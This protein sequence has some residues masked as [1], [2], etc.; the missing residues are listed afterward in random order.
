MT[1]LVVHPVILS[2]GKVPRLIFLACFFP[3]AI[4]LLVLG[5]INRRRYPM[6]VSGVWDFIG[7]LFAASGFLLLAGP[8][9]LSNMNEGWRHYWL[10]GKSGAPQPTLDDVWQFWVFLS[11]LYFVI[12]VAGSG[13]LLWRHRSLTSIYNI[14]AG[15]VQRSLEVVFERLH[16]NPVRSG[17]IYLFGLAGETA[18]P[19]VAERYESVQ[20]PHHLPG[21]I[22]T[23]VDSGAPRAGEGDFLGQTAILEIESFGYFRH[24][25]LRWDPVDNLFRRE[26]EGQLQ[27]VLSRTP[28]SESAVGAWM[29]LTGMGLLALLFL[30]SILFVLVRVLMQKE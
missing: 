1:G 4:Y 8:A 3:V 24:V 6:M 20:G 5:A 30:G 2:L 12:V 9:I 18:A 13:Y 21:A 22:T 26:I 17:N 27:Q 25:T 15:K 10:L 11:I 28:T 29:L 23:R 16:L 7:L 14:E 19:P